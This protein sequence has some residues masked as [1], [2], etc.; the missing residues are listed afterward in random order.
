MK[1]TL[2]VFFIF[3]LSGIF[4]QINQQEEKYQHYIQLADQHYKNRNYDEAIQNYE[5]SVMIKPTETYPLQI[6]F[7]ILGIVEQQKEIDAKVAH[8][9]QLADSYF[10]NKY[11][12]QAHTYYMQILTIKVSEDLAKKRLMEIDDIRTRKEDEN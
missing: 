5:L 7:E 12:D 8:L 4:S 1:I 11:F 6:I 10:T 9:Y 2:S 3:I